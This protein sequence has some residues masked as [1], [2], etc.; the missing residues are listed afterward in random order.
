M[1]LN[2]AELAPK[3]SAN[4][5]TAAMVNPRAVCECA[6]R[7]AQVLPELR[8]PPRAARVSTG[9]LHLFE[10]AEL[11]ADDPA[12]FALI[13]TGAYQIGDSRF[14]MEPQFLVELVFLFRAVPESLQPVH[15]TDTDGYL[16]LLPM[17]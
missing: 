4:V 16:P 5:S 17:L 8:K 13:Q 14:D 15:G 1:T 7:V 12:G 10:A 11:V 2:M 6:C 9:F 3:P